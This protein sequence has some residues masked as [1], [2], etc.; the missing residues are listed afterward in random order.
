M[1]TILAF[2]F[3]IVLSQ[4]LQ[5]IRYFWIS[6]PDVAD[7]LVNTLPAKVVYILLRL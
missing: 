4:I 5:I 1:T 6:T 7:V 2:V 3:F